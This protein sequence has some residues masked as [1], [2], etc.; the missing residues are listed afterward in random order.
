MKWTRKNPIG[1]RA[2]VLGV[3]FSLWLLVIG[4][5]VI[6]LQV[7]RGD[8]LSE[9]ASDQVEASVE[10]DG[11]RGV[12]FD[13]NRREMAVSIDVTSIGANPRKVDDVN[14]TSAVLADTL[15][16]DRRALPSRGGVFP[17]R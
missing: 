17:Q 9:K 12:I 7:F 3:F 8:W 6:Y 13:C 4:A 1:L 16:I 15:R 10:S 14:R 5:K 11:K 2:S